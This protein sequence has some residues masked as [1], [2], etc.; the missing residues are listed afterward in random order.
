MKKLLLILLCLPLLGFGQQT[1]VP[2]DN[3]EQALINLGYDNVLDDSVTTS[4]IDT[5]SHLDVN[6]LNIFDLTGIEDFNALTF[7]NCTNNQLTTLDV[8]NNTN[9]TYLYCNGNQLTSL[10]VSQNT[11]LTS[12]SCSF[13]QLTTLD[14]S[15]N[16]NL[17]ILSCGVNQLTTLDVSQN[18]ALTHLICYD[19]QLSSLDV[20]QN[21]ALDF[22]E[23]RSNQLT[24]LDVSQ[25]PALTYLNCYDN[26]LSSLDVSQNPALT[27]LNCYN[28]QLSS[29]DLRN[30]NNSNFFYFSSTVNPNLYCIDVDD[31]AWADTNW[32][33]FN[34][35]INSTMSFSTNC[36]MALGCTDSLACNY[37]STATI[38]DGS[39]VYSFILTNSVVI[40]DGDSVVVGSSIYD[41]SG[42]YVDTLNASNG[43]DSIVN[44]FIL[45]EQNTSFFD[46]LSVNTSILW[47]GMLIDS[48][49]DYS[50]VYTNMFG[51]DSIVN[52]NLTVTTTG[53]SDIANNKSNLVKITNMLGQRTPY[54]KNTPLI[55]IYDD[56]TVEKKITI[57]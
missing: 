2:D 47:N 42:N 53:V 6:F 30:G 25:N 12:L 4:A 23:C 50:I 40:C 45:V 49:G 19:N 16:T 14:V 32:T 54:R 21:I 28:N 18:P 51:C 33:P 3:F 56:G 27:H 39:C 13:N 24:T 20:S 15:Q 44:T 8:S 41:S 22:F 36:L 31:V 5:V 38:D 26:Q 17:T 11:N 34:G 52:L 7:L 9:L 57:D 48:S 35:N 37:D 46:T 10:D 1:Y 55:Y 29:L 43:C